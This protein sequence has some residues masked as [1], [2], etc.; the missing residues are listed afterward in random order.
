MKKYQYHSS[1]VEIPT[2]TKWYGTSKTDPHALV[3][4]GYFKDHLNEM[5][6]EGWRLA[7]IEPLVAPISTNAYSSTTV[8]YYLFWEKEA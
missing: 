6:N 8:G 2:E 7:Q 3:Q 1:F 4:S 5:G